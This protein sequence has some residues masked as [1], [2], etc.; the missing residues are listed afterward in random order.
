MSFATKAK[1]EVLKENIENDCCSI[2]FL[3]AIIK[4]SGELS[5]SSNHQIKVEIFTEIPELFDKIKHIIEQYYGKVCEMSMMENTNISRSSRYKITLPYDI[6]DQL[7]KDLG[8]MSID[9]DG[10]LAIEN[11]IADFLIMDDCCK[12][13]YVKGAFV[14]CATSNI[15]IKNYNNDRGSGYHLEFVFNF[16]KIAEDFLKLLSN[17]DITAKITTRKN[18]PIVYIK[19]YQLICD[20]L[21][22]VGANKA[23]LDLQNEAA[24]RELRNNVNR[25][26]NC[27]NANLNKTVQAS[28]K[29]LNAIKNIQD[30]MGLESLSENLMELALLRLA[31][32]EATLEELRQLSTQKLT[33]SGVNHRFAKIIEISDNITKNKF[34]ITTL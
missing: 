32:P 11:G 29:Q 5:I 20:T 8:I 12:R 24:I 4:C 17:F 21:A 28:V 3:S 14:A 6:T 9:Q 30:N 13:S 26:N 31:N 33:K 15:V 18:S 34:K 1:L 7:L 10:M 27:L 19:E 16:D 2:A 25:Q 23:V 22:L